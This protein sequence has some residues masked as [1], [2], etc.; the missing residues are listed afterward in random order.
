MH[1]GDRARKKSVVDFGFRRP[2][3]YEKCSLQFDEF[4]THIHQ[5]VYVSAT[6]GEWELVEAGGDVVQQIISPTGLLD[7]TIEVRPVTNPVDDSLDE[8]RIETEKGGRVLVTTL[9]KKL[10]ERKIFQSI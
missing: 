7:P 4:Y 5:V 10:K 3:G 8:I 6:P 9:T 2:Y 1:N